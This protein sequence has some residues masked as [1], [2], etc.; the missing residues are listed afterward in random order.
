MLIDVLVQPRASRARLG[1]VVGER[2]KVAVTAPPVDGKANA[3]VIDLVAKTLRVAR[4]QIEVESGVT[5]RRK[6][7]RVH[8][9]GRDEVLARIL[10]VS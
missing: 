8:G 1:P 2:L 6:S 3:A 10:E 7:L 9:A 4:R 5:S